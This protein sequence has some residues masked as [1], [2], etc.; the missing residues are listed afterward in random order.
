MSIVTI[1]AEILHETKAAILI[2]SDEGVKCWLPFSLIEIHPEE[3]EIDL[4][5]W[6]A[7]EK[8]LI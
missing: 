7:I 6:L 2:R 8:E 5:E 3:G 4:P 1:K